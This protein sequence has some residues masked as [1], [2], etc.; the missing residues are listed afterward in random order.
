MIC[1]LRLLLWWSFSRIHKAGVARAICAS[2]I[3]SEIC[4]VR[5]ECPQHWAA[6][7]AAGKAQSHT[8]KAMGLQPKAKAPSPWSGG[9]SLSGC[10]HDVP[11]I[12]IWGVDVPEI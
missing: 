11:T 3:A 8:A 6:K 9:S 10:A 2:D 4:T 7:R 1:L 5:G 12:P